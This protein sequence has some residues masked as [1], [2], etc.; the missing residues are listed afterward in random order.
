MKKRTWQRLALAI[1]SVTG[2]LMIVL[3]VHVYIVTRPRSIDASTRAMARIDILQPITQADADK[4]TVWFYQQKGVD[5][6]LVNPQSN[7]AVFT[8]FPVRTTANQVADNFKVHMPYKA[9]RFIPSPEALK[10]GCP[11]ASSSTMYNIYSWLKNIF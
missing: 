3:A 5:H 7:I 11:V 9:E 4:I 6:V 2:L 8:F 10:R 1:L